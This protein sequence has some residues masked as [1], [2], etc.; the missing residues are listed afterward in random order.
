VEGGL[1]ML[2]Y[3]NFGNW[4]EPLPAGLN[5]ATYLAARPP[6]MRST[7]QRKLSRAVREFRF[8]A[9]QSTGPALEAAIVAY[10]DVRAQSWKPYEPFP[11]F[12]AAL[13]R[14]TAKTGQCRV[15]VLRD[16][17]GTPVAAQYW[18]VS[19]GTAFLLKLCHVESSRS[20]SPGTA[21]TAMMIR[22]LIEED[23]VDELDFGRGDDAYKQLWVTRRRER[24]GV[25]LASRWHPA[26]LAA[27]M[28]HHAAR[29][30]RRGARP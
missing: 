13:L 7:I 3:R 24:E 11:K 27:I 5:W 2:R 25:I 29:W 14:A 6:A 15:G 8:E 16:A 20:A 19:G 18:I 12:D 30:V 17:G 4:Y 28:R 22:R 26:G 21:L 23:S 9:T 10:E 1:A